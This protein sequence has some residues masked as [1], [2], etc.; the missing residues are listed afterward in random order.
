MNSKGT[1]TVVKFISED[2]D[3]DASV[4]AVPSCWLLGNNLCY[5]PSLPKAKVTKAIK[6]LE[7]N[8]CWPSHKI[9]VFRGATYG[10]YNTA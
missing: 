6:N 3:K 4:E 2:D 10:K 7:L 8:T 5:W 1:W 9:E